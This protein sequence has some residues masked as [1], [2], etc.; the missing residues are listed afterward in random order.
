M[1]DLTSE[2]Q[3]LIMVR[4]ACYADSKEI[5]RNSKRRMDVKLNFIRKSAYYDPLT[6]RAVAN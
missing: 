1:A 6:R 3:E 4:L 2:Q 5:I